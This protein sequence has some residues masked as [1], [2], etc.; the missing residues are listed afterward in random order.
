MIQIDTTGEWW[1]DKDEHQYIIQ[2]KTIVKEGKNAGGEYFT[3]KS[4]HATHEQV[5]KQIADIALSKAIDRDL[6]G[7]VELI[8]GFKYK[9]K[10]LREFK[11]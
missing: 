7:M 5:I 10:E 1:I 6:I 3:D 11:R 2:R 9:F 8:E 4:Y